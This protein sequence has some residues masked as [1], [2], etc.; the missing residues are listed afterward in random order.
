M[1]EMD[2]ESTACVGTKSVLRT[3]T[4]CPIQALLPAMTEMHIES[5]RCARR[6]SCLGMRIFN[7]FQLFSGFFTLPE[8]GGG[9]RWKEV[10][11]ER[12]KSGNR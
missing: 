4:S 11:R 1:T 3:D 10:E 8:N 6:F 7:S 12:K 9:K 2:I 5:R